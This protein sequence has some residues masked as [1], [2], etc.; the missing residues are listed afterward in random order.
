M[1]REQ[2]TFGNVP[3]P[4]AASWSSEEVPGGARMSRRQFIAKLTRVLWPWRG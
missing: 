4:Y 2:L 1:A 3:V